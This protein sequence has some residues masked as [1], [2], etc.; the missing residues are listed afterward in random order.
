MLTLDNYTITQLRL[1]Y[2]EEY[3]KQIVDFAT[4]VAYFEL[5]GMQKKADKVY[6]CLLENAGVNFYIEN[7]SLLT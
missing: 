7:F 5:Y 4:Q 6:K 1:Q 2:P 3:K